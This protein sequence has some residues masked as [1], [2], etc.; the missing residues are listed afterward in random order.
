[1]RGAW[2]AAWGLGTPI[3]PMW[4]FGH[5]SV[6]TT[7][8]CTRGAWIMS[9]C[10]A[11]PCTHVALGHANTKLSLGSACCR[12]QKKKYIYIYIYI[13]IYKRIWEQEMKIQK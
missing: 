11:H 8:L 7:L 9:L 12:S 4:R 1:M 10:W 5:A 6:L 13:Y 3:T 2:A